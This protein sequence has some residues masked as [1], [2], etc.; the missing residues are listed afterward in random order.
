MENPTQKFALIG[1]QIEPLFIVL[2]GEERCLPEHNYGPICRD[3][4]I[5]HFVISGKGTYKIGN[6]KY[7]L[8]ENQGFLIPQHALIQYT[9]D[10]E[11]PW[12]YCW[13]QLKGNGARKYFN[14]LSLSENNPIYH[15]RPEND[16]Y[17]QFLKILSH[18]QK[19]NQYENNYYDLYGMIFQ[20]MHTLQKYN[21]DP[22]SSSPISIQQQ[23]IQQAEYYLTEHYHQCDLTI[24]EVAESI[25]L[26][27]SYLSRIFKEKLKQSPQDYLIY[28]RMMHAKKLLINSMLPINIIARSVGYDNIF[29]FSKMYKKIHGVSPKK[30]QKTSPDND[31]PKD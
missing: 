2:L 21:A 25:G 7:E 24:S 13:I 9:A 26:N 10:K 14:D 22:P 8:H 31:Q 6:K 3:S 11:E 19:I 28:L 29:N 17:P 5:F 20:F 15:A 1:Q 4:H 12:H 27:R 23:Y 30:H 18:A 16:I